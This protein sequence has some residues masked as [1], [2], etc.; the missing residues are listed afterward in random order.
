MTW[1]FAVVLVIIAA[2]AVAQA[3][4]PAPAP[5]AF[6]VA[7]IRPTPPNPPVT[8]IGAP[9]PGGRWS[10]RNVTVLMIVSRAYPDYALRGMIVGGP[11]WVAERHFDI[12]ARAAGTPTPAQYTQMIR[13]LLVDRF[14]LK[15]HTEP[16]PLDVYSLVLARTDGRLG[17][18]LR[19]AS[20]E[21]TAELDAARERE[22]AWLAGSGVLPT[23]EPPPP[24]NAR[25]SGNNGMMRISGGRSM[26][27]L[28]GELRSWTGLK[29]VDRTGLRGDYEAELEFD[30][31][32]TSSVA[33]NPD[34]SKPSIFTA[35]QEQLGLKLERRR[36]PVDVLVIDA[37]EMPSEN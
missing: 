31:R 2:A 19:P 15:T 8:T 24:C 4:V 12:D 20:P 18:G 17:P 21:C 10:P 13:Q 11:D 16:R 35:V 7:S 22:R 6:D 33:L 26:N 37:I 32:A 30:R 28:A 1:K 3:Q 34:S 29:V 9:L 23:A 36:E 27:E 25:V 5:L 14:K